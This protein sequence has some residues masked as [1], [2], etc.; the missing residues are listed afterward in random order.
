MEWATAQEQR[1]LAEGGADDESRITWLYR[2]IL[3]R[4]PTREELTFV[5]KALQ[6]QRELYQADPAAASKAI[7][8]GESLPKN[9]APVEETNG[10][11]LLSPIVL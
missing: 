1:I 2:T 8:V 11:F 3:S 6:T 5:S 4:P 9:I 10:K 7:H